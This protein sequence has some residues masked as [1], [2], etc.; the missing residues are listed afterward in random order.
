MPA[1]AKA[2]GLSFADGLSSRAVASFYQ[3]APGYCD[4]PP[5]LPAVQDCR[6]SCSRRSPF[7]SVVRVS[8]Y[9]GSILVYTV[10]IYIIRRIENIYIPRI[11]Y[12]PMLYGIYIYNIIIFFT[13]SMYVLRTLAFLALSRFVLLLRRARFAATKC[14]VSRV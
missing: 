2:T 12:T 1:L 4:P 9:S 10:Y 11:L 6:G 13:Y 5:C 3:T 8:I 7:F 14:C